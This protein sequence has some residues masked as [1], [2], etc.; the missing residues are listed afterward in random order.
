MKTSETVALLDVNL[1]LALFHDGHVHHDVAH[2]WFAEHGETGWASCP[3]TENGLARI[4]GNP[5]RVQEHHPLPGIVDLLRTFCAHSKHT[6]WADDISLQDRHRFNLEAIRGH[7]QIADVYLLGL[8]VK[9]G[10]RFVT[11]DQRIPLAAV[12]GATRASLEVIAPA[13]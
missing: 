2:D 7:Q 5:A 9:N 12:T 3:L 11:L 10:G 4:L 8:A 6:F 13:E 1:L